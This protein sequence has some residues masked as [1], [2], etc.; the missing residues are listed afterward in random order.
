MYDDASSYQTGIAH[1]G[2]AHCSAPL[3]KAGFPQQVVPGCFPNVK[4]SEN[5]FLINPKLYTIVSCPKHYPFQSFLSDPD[6][7]TDPRQET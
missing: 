3:V 6:K 4:E 5:E 2:F 1:S 7:P